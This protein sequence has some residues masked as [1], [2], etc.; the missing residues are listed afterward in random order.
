MCF[1]DF[2]LGVRSDVS[3]LCDGYPLFHL[4]VYRRIVCTDAYKLILLWAA[5]ATRL[6]RG[7]LCLAAV[8]GSW[9]D[10]IVHEGPYPPVRARHLNATN[11]RGMVNED[12]DACLRLTACWQVIEDNGE[13][14]LLEKGNYSTS[15]TFTASPSALR[16]FTWRQFSSGQAVEFKFYNW[17]DWKDASV[18]QT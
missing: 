3:F 10:R 1:E 5:T 2:C 9:A 4:G 17:Q 6:S 15:S 18:I 13:T 11:Q 12:S 14:L 16:P 8:G 7:E